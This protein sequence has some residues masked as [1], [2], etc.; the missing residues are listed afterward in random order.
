MMMVVFQR[1][2]IYMGY[3]PPGAR[4]E[5]LS[6][7]PASQVKGLSVREICVR[8]D[9]QTL[10]GVTV[11]RHGQGEPSSIMLYFQGNAGNTLHRLP[12]FQSI[13]SSSS[14]TSPPHPSSRL[15]L[16]R[17]TSKHS[18]HSLEIVCV[19]PRS[20]WKSTGS[21]SGPSQRSLTSDY[22]AALHYALD[23]YPPHIPITIYGHSLGATIAICLLSSLSDERDSRY[24]RIQGLI[25]ENPFSSIPNMVEALYPQKWVPYQ[26]LTPFVLDRWDALAAL[27]ETSPSV[28]RRL[29]S[30]ALVLT[31][32]LDEVVPPEMGQEVY[33][34]MRLGF[35]DAPSEGKAGA[36]ECAPHRG[37]LEVIRGALHENCWTKTQWRKAMTGY[38]LDL[39]DALG[40]HR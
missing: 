1:K 40:F 23:A 20:Y 15:S 21:P 31:S 9:S 14:S 12:V 3:I 35:D 19:S 10:Y 37:R 30:D 25:L 32:E 34:R 17:H 18:T 6:D 29:N 33:R 5:S 27:D 39:E 26:Y 36:L 28:L 13:L 24:K 22:H 11:G 4:Q 8:G 2:I 38:M 7:V 16:S